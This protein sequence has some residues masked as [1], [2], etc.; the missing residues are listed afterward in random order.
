MECSICYCELTLQNTVNTRC[1][2][3]FCS[4]CFWKWVSNNNTCPMCRSGVVTN[5][6]LNKEESSLRASIFEL[7]QEE[8]K[9]YD[10][11][12]YLR[13]EERQLERDVFQLKKFRNRKRYCHCFGL[14][15]CPVRYSSVVSLASP[16]IFNPAIASIN[17]FS[18]IA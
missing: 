9:L 5:N 12:D 7:T 13:F 8:T 2:H 15:T 6:S 18:Y 10:N 3:T 11:I 17:L 1:S 4:E 14:I 16:N